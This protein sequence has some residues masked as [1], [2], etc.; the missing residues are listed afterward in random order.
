MEMQGKRNTLWIGSSV[1][2]E[3]VLDCV[4]YNNNLV[5]RVVMSE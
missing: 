5:K 4:I 3:S 1:C 2:F